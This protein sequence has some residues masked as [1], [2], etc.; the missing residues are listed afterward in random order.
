MTDTFVT[1]PKPCPDCLKKDAQIRVERV[2]GT[3]APP[4]A[5]APHGRTVKVT[6]GWCE[7]GR[8]RDV[9]VIT[10][11]PGPDGELAAPLMVVENVPAPPRTIITEAGGGVYADV[12]VPAAPVMEGLAELGLTDEEIDHITSVATPMGTITPPERKRTS[13]HRL[14]GDCCECG[15]HPALRLSVHKMRAWHRE[16]K[17]LLDG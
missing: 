17:A 7:C 13:G 8:W 6:H 11:T 2:L 4:T 15:A 10:A 16:H 14:T 1:A 5:E 9:M 3:T 12:V